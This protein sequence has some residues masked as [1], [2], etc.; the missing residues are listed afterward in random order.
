MRHSR[1][2]SYSERLVIERM[3]KQ[4]AT[5]KQIA[6][7]LGVSQQAIS[8]EL[9]KGKYIH[10]GN[11]KDFER[12]SADVAQKVINDGK[13]NKGRSCKFFELDSISIDT[14][15]YSIK[16]K[17]FSPYA[18]LCSLSSCLGYC[19][20]SLN[21]LYKYIRRG[22][23]S[24]ISRADLPELCK[25]KEKKIH[26]CF[27]VKKQAGK[28]IELRP[29][30]INNRSRFGD[31]EGDCVIGKKSGIGEVLF[32]LTERLTRFELIFKMDYKR[33]VSVVSVL[34]NL[35][36]FLDFPKVFKSIT[37]DNGSEFS[38]SAGM[39]N[40]MGEKR[41]VCYFAHPYSS[42]ERGTNERHNRI[43]RRFFPKGQSIATVTQEDCY[44]VARWMN[45]LPRRIL[46][47]LS[48]AEMLRNIVDS[49]IYN[50][51]ADFI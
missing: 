31:W 9:K 38:D 27:A 14:L 23:L 49:D 51:L 25:K 37:F 16:Q 29:C 21:S 18:A 32:T 33:A 24:G 11:Y 2:L 39:E 6:D 15:I 19:P 13:K 28:S 20:F 48:P 4:N 3:L 17:K 40:C 22:F 36:C 35:S 5:Q 7:V 43:I 10:T 45:N 42:F 41:T 44:F 34:D 26:S 30:I 12:Y 46:G 47:G 8:K 1:Y 50:M